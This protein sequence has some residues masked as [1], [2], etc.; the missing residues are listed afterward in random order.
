MLA[1]MRQ[2]GESEMEKQAAPTPAPGN[3]LPCAAAVAPAR[4]G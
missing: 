1:A 2:D 4:G 3:E